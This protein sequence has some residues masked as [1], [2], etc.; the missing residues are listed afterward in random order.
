MEKIS[1]STSKEVDIDEQM[2]LEDIINVVSHLLPSQGPIQS[3]VH[4]NTLHHFEE[5]N[6]F[7]GV[8]KAASIYSARPYLS[9]Q[10]YQEEYQRGRIAQ[11]DLNRALKESNLDGTPWM[12]SYSKRKLYRSLMLAAPVSSNSETLRWRLLEDGQLEKFHETVHQEK[13]N[14][15]LNQDKENFSKALIEE[16]NSKISK[17]AKW[18]GYV[19]TIW[20]ERINK[21]VFEKKISE[22]MEKDSLILLWLASALLALEFSPSFFEHN[23][24]YSSQ[25]PSHIETLVTPYVVK[26]TAAFLDVGLA[27][28]HVSN[29]SKG[30]L[31]SF[32]EHMKRASLLRPRW[33]RHDFSQYE[34]RESKEIIGMI[35]RDW[36]V[37]V[38]DWQSF[39]LR[40]A[41]LLKGWAGMIVQAKKNISEFDVCADLSDFL[42]IRLLLEHAAKQHRQELPEQH[43]VD[44]SLF[45]GDVSFDYHAY[46]EHAYHL[47]LTFQFWGVSGVQ[48]LLQSLEERAML[49]EEIMRFP[50]I[51]RLRTWHKAYEWNL[52]SRAAAAIISHNENI[53][54]QAKQAKCQILCCLDDREESFRRHIEEMNEEYET[55]GTAGF[56][57]V[58]AE[59]HSLYERPAAFCPANV[60]PTHRV[61]VRPK[62]GR[63]QHFSGV[64]WIKKVRS[65]IE[66]MM[67]AESRSLVK[68]WFLA[69]AGV[70]ALIP[71]SFSTL[72]PGLSYKIKKYLKHFLLTSNDEGVLVYAS[73]NS[74]T[75]TE[76]YTLEE[77]IYRV[78]T[79]LL[80]SGM[81]KEIAPL[82]IIMGHG[83]F[84]SNNPYRSAYDCGACGG[85]PARLNPRVFSLMANRKDVREGI[86]KEG[87]N[88]SDT[89][90]FVAA[91]HNTCTDEVEYFDVDLLPDTHQKLFEKLRKDIEVARARNALERCRRFDEVVLHDAR[92]AL[93]HAES[94]AYHIAQP[95]PEYG[96]ATNAFCVIGRRQFTRDLFLDRR[97]FLVSYDKTVDLD[98]SALSNLL[99]AVIPVCMGIN[100]EYFFSSIDNQQYGAGTK[101]PHN[102]VSLLGLMSGYCSDLRTGLPSQMVEIHEPV[103]LM[104]VIEAEP[105]TLKE[106]II[107][108]SSIRKAVENQWIVLF[109]Y[110]AETNALYYL[111]EKGEFQLFDEM[112]IG[113]SGTSSSLDWAAGRDGH[114]EFVQIRR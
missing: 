8:E 30:L 59:F 14:K 112:N 110:S 86:K 74:D 61:H 1:S 66:V 100:L 33:L 46:P 79:L 2:L 92:E 93:A 32:L 105:A 99:R 19:P 77:M 90:H 35:L 11:S 41:L 87:I 96:H 83:S 26:F 88:I 67:E 75:D 94:R 82:V 97:A 68:G 37:P 5:Y 108:E 23:I 56:F 58:D 22:W 113:I 4:H 17:I 34:G 3:F 109:S 10:R 89:T 45:S 29:R 73:E 81:V 49:V 20:L 48:L 103:R 78:K 28:L 53:H 55:F 64:K 36:Q 18:G 60:L 65:E 52:Y 91:Y 63:E 69:S 80:T 39:L 111:T 43:G 71:L 101:L 47:F 114:L 50:K 9:E 24:E 57:G 25:P 44:S 13:R 84:S 6:F 16:I 107:N 106:I 95:R 12:F 102:V 54:H 21:E 76:H 31:F 98:S 70:L 7:D 40:K 62:P 15:F 72:S 42:C 51:S 85:R 27:H 38:G 104:T